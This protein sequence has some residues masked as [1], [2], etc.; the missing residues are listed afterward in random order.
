MDLSRVLI[1]MWVGH[2]APRRV[3]RVSGGRRL[4]ACRVKT[5]RACLE[6]EGSGCQCHAKESELWAVGRSVYL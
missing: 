1:G 3:K 4:K 5:C 2:Q 6:P